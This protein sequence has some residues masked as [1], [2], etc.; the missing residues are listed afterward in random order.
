MKIKSVI[1]SLLAVLM[2]MSACTS[3]QSVHV[4][5][6]FDEGEIELLQALIENQS[7]NR[8]ELAVS[9]NESKIKVTRASTLR[10]GINLNN[11]LPTLVAIASSHDDY[12]PEPGLNHMVFGPIVF[13][14]SMLYG[15][16]DSVFY[17][18]FI[19]GNIQNFYVQ[20]CISVT[21]EKGCLKADIGIHLS[22]GGGYM[23][24]P[25][26]IIIELEGLK[27]E[28]VRSAE[29]KFIPQERK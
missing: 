7:G 4:V 19:N 16:G 25:T 17:V 18:A 12:L 26:F 29:L 9:N 28:D 23:M 22:G 10:A 27:S 6:E 5:K 20:E 11:E 21:L 15:S 2:L 13:D 3:Q 14:K 8:K 1:I 24:T